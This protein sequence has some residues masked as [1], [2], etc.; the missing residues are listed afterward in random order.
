VGAPSAPSG[1]ASSAPATGKR[2]SASWVGDKLHDAKDWAGDKLDDIENW[3]EDKIEGL[4][5]K[6]SPGLAELI[7]QG[8]GG[9][10][11]SAIEP[12]ISGWV[13]T[14]TGGVNVG[15]I[16]GQ[17][18]GTFTSAFAVLE[19]AKGGDPKCCETLVSGIN[20]I[21][22]IAGAFIDSPVF[23]AIKGIFTKVSDIVGTITKLV[24]GPAFEVLKT[25]LGGAWDAIKG[26]ASTIQKWFTAV[27][28]IASKAFDWLAKK[29]GFSSGTGEGGLLDWLQQKAASIW[30]TIKATLA[31]VMGPLKVIGGLLL[32]LTPLPE[33]YAIVKYGPEI[34][35]AVKWL[36]NNRNN[37]DAVKQNPGGLGG[38][39]LPKI[40]GAGQSFVS[41]IKKGA[42][43]LV[44]K[45]TSFANG[46]LG[47]LGAI[48]GVPL[49]D[50]AHG[51]AQAIV[52]GIQGVQ[53][54]ATGAF[55]SAAGWLETTF[56][57]VADFIKP[58]A[59]V[60]CSVALAITQPEMIPMIIAG[61]AWKWLPDCIKPPLIDLLLDA[62]I[63]VLRGM[64]SLPL[65]G[66]LWPLLK[67]GVL[68]FLGAVRAKDPNTK[69]KVSN[70][71]AKIIAGASPSFL[72]GF[73]KGLLRGVWDGI[74]MPFEAI[75]MIAKG[76]GKA[77]DFFV[78]L[79]HDADAKQKAI[80]P[81]APV[82]AAAA[83]PAAPARPPYASA[84]PP[85]VP[86]EINPDETTAV[87]SRIVAQL[88]A[89]RPARPST[90]GPAAAPSGPASKTAAPA[91]A[92]PAN[93]YAALG[94]EAHHMAQELSGP[95]HT[96]ATGFWPAVQQL[97]SSSGK[98]MSI[99]SLMAKLGKVWEAAKQAVAAQG[100]KLGNTVCDFLMK[101]SAE[102]EIGDTVGY[103]VGMV[104]FQALLDA[105]TADTW[106]GANAILVGI[107]EF[108]NWPMKFLGEAMKG[109][110]LLG[111]FLLKGIKDLRGS[112]DAAAGALHSVLGAFEDI[113]KKL[114]EFADEILGKFGKDIGKADT[115]AAHAAEA[116]TARAAET[117]A[118]GTAGKDAKAGK[119]GEGKPKDNEPSSGQSTAEREAEKAEEFAEA[120]AIA[121]G[122]M[123]AEDAGRVPGPAIATSL[124]A[125]K[126]RY[127]WIKTFEA[128]PK[129][130]GYEMFLIASSED[131]GGVGERGKAKPGK[132]EPG[133]TEPGKTEPQQFCTPDEFEDLAQAQCGGTKGRM[134]LS[135]P[136]PSGVDTV[137]CDLIDG[138]ALTQ[139]KRI[140]S[141][142]AT[143]GGKM[144]EQFRMT[145]DAAQLSNRRI[146]RYIVSKEAPQAFLDGIRAMPL[147]AGLE[148]DLVL[149][150]A[151][152]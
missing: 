89:Q 141:P 102:E 69:I 88:N 145:V 108:L 80:K 143:F 18:K 23:D 53:Q 42:A 150:S 33:I 11:K 115:T 30:E 54:W 52:D 21:R 78:N 99:D 127:R 132:T 103:L 41:M 133:K 20:A 4:V 2:A 34:V 25:F 79:G 36:W 29:L 39:I 148:L 117:D 84:T 27:K 120:V 31:P 55:T 129:T 32:L 100:A 101:D 22:S 97:F 83:A 16:A 110:K 66:P 122:I 40:L 47:L 149:I 46:A 44:E 123:H 87:V 70:K 104:A 124:L 48:T 85:H 24:I 95:G 109:F 72:L 152:K 13:G 5:R 86:G 35:E 76:I 61:W 118:A 114:G 12:A 3:A 146:I 15:K 96:V 45:A 58:Y 73:V 57:R 119:D 60:L 111:G 128:K 14:V 92:A 10:I 37:P 63:K 125:L 26:V 135:Q 136:R 28:N 75:W 74:K 137:E 8:P 142:N 116:D 65:L 139:I 43:W 138:E 140:T 19:G 38:T 9:M 71:L 6:V 107:A 64:P 130:R 90:Q 106:T 67:S 7:D 81:A 1:P 62:V 105:L 91:A 68:G 82:K 17:L 151:V 77:G 147:P 112:F 131:L 121:K 98:G 126:S 144:Q 93:Q 49:L 59:D 50:M 134:P 113:G 51:F 56:H 94:Q